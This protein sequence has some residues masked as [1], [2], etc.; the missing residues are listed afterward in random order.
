MLVVN[1]IN[2]KQVPFNSSGFSEKIVKRVYEKQGYKVYRGSFLNVVNQEDKGIFDSYSNVGYKYGKLIQNLSKKLGKE[3]FDELVQYCE[4][5]AGTPDYFI[6]GKDYFF[7]ECKLGNE[8]I[9]L[10]QYEN[11]NFIMKEIGIPVKILRV[12]DKRNRRVEEVIDVEK[13][14]E[15]KD[16]VRK[17]KKVTK[18]N[19]KLKLRW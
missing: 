12:C 3:R 2:V 19:A 15:N 4:V 18:R 17:Y 11:I 1:F 6:S 7:V 14:L 16:N 5:N 13:Y 9:K 10:N 8:S